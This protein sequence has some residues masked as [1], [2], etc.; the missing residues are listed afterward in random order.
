MIVV[1][2]VV[3]DYYLTAWHSPATPVV[4][5]VV[6]SNKEVALVLLLVLVQSSQTTICRDIS[7]MDVKA[8]NETQLLGSH[9]IESLSDTATYNSSVPDKNMTRTTKTNTTPA[10]NRYPEQE[11]Q[12]MIPSHRRCH[13]PLCCPHG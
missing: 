6:V 3:V 11:C 7:E 13:R 8:S 5:A 9:H 2:V 4:L 12:M 10:K 1:V